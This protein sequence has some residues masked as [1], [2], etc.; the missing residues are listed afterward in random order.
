M[1]GLSKRRVNAAHGFARA[2]TLSKLPTNIDRE[3]R[4]LLQLLPAILELRPHY[5]RP[6]R[7][8][9]LC[10]AIHEVSQPA[11]GRLHVHLGDDR[12]ANA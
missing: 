11:S 1:L 4:T 5:F 12:L 9:R 10:G 7:L 2:A 8:G 6:W 3:A